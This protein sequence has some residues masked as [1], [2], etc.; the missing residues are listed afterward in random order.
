MIIG[1]VNEKC[2]I[3]KGYF[4]EIEDV[5]GRIKVFIGLDKEGVNEVYSMIMFDFVVVF[6]GIFGKGIFF[7]NRVFFLDVL[8]FKR[9]KLL[10]EEK[11]YVI[12][13]SDIYVGSNKFCEEVFIKFF[14]WFNGEVNSRIEEEL[15]SRIKYIIIGGD[16]VDGVGIYLG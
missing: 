15:V 13:F 5:M 14:E 2:E 8:K 1:F 9:L 7:V 3:R 12:L 16:V 6:R 4:F 10:F 11:V